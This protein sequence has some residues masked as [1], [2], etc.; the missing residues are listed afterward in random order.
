MTRSEA[1]SPGIGLSARLAL[2]ALE[3]AAQRGDQQVDLRGEV[4][5]ERAEG[6]VGLLG[7]GPHLDRVEATLGGQRDGRVEDALAA[8]ALR[9]RA[10]VVDRER[11]RAGGRISDGAHLVCPPGTCAAF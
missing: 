3:L 9:G 6:D 2:G 4:A 8:V 5:V 10:E 1:V 11:V 7:D